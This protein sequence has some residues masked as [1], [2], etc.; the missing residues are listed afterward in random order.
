MIEW[1]YIEKLC[2]NIPTFI[3]VKYLYDVYLDQNIITF[4]L[5]I[6]FCTLK[7]Y[8]YLYLNSASG[9]HDE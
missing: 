9:M 4:S 2:S 5:F 1:F 6:N 7:K 8:V 3:N